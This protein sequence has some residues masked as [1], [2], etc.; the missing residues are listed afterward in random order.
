MKSNINL[1]R[2]WN[3]AMQ[4]ERSDWLNMMQWEDDREAY[5]LAEYQTMR[6]AIRRRL[7]K[8]F[9]EWL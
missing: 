1:W 5:N 6:G 9:D 2:Q 3:R 8:E 4:L 7:T